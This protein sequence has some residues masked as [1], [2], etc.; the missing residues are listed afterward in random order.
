MR[1]KHLLFFSSLLLVSTALHSCED[2]VAVDT[3]DYKLDS[4]S[5]YDNDHSAESALN[6]LFNQLFN[7]SFSGGGAQSVSYLTGLSADNYT[8]TSTTQD[9]NEFY[10]NKISPDNNYNLSL[11][12][13]AYNII[14]QANAL[15]KGVSGNSRLST[16]TIDRIAGSSRF[17]RAFTYFYLVNL[18]GDVPLLLGKDYQEN[19][20]AAN[21]KS[22][23]INN[24]IIDDLE[25]AA[26][27]LQEDYPDGDRTRPNRFA[28]LALLA[29]VHLFLGNWEQA[30]AY[31]SQVIASSKYQIPVDPD[32]VFLANSSEAIWQISPVGWGNS[33]THTRDGNLLIKTPTTST[34]VAMSQKFLNTFDD[35]KDKRLNDWV[36]TFVEE[37]D[38]LY[39]P[40]K[41]KIQYDASGGDIKEYSMVLRLAEQYLI[42]AEAN[43]RINDLNAAVNDINTIRFR[44]GIH[45]ITELP[46]DLTQNKLLTIIL[47]ERRRELFSEWGHRWFDLQRFDLSPTLK[48]KEN[49]E[50][51]PTSNR[52]PIPSSERMKNPNLKQNPGY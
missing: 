46:T 10:R 30:L 7:T 9:I 45:P 40:Y 44:A 28:A 49:S 37:G 21:T 24:Q 34:P 42:R 17:V 47:N 22:A 39:F 19:A 6:G 20:T 16:P 14:Y 43:A 36:S 50:W 13:G 41:Y 23:L 48:D 8:L 29:R 51:A 26:R 27:L 2:F 4:Q 3:P 35:P 1:I 25:M 33:F 52:F 38:S 11:W 32:M 31:S 5:V 15:L 12:S 18:Y